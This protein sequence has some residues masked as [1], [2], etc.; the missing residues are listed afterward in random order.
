MQKTKAHQLAED[1]LA[2]ELR[3]AFNMLVTEYKESCERHTSDHSK[4]VNYNILADL[5]K[6]G[7]RKSNP[8]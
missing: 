3:D 7:W 4:R 5:V 2:P 6:A 1:A 8:N